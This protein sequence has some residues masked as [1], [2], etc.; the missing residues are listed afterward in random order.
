MA[1]ARSLSISLHNNTSVMLTIL[2]APRPKGE[3]GVPAPR[4]GGSMSPAVSLVFVNGAA[5]PSTELGGAIQLQSD[6]DDRVIDIRWSWPP[7]AAPRASADYQA[8]IERVV[9]TAACSDQ[10]TPHPTFSVTF[11]NP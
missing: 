5:S 9:V 6:F 7:E 11:S 2:Q 3:W 10:Q 8:G 4:P 1:F